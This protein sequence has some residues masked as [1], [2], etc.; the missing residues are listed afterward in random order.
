MKKIVL[1]LISVFLFSSAFSQVEVKN[2][3][4]PSL[5]LKDLNG[6]IVN[7]NKYAE[8]EKITVISVWATWCAPCIKEITNINEILDD[9]YDEYDME[10]VI[11]SIDNS[12]NAMKVK[13][14]VNGKG[15]DFDALLDVNSDTKRALNYSNPPFT[16]LVNK[17]G[18]IVYR[19]TGYVE[20]DEYN[21]EEEIIKKSK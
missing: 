17:D 19:H 10:F 7:L 18:E 12:R 2:K 13:P 16:L 5:E 15:W 3:K 1:L 20:G 11:I 6:K 8:N 9:W 4:L 21:L 14:F